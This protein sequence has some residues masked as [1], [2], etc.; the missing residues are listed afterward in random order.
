MRAPLRVVAVDLGAESGRCAVGEFDG[1]TIRLAEVHRFANIPVQLPD[2]LHWDVLRLFEEVK[3]G[4]RRAH[5]EGALASLGLDTWGVDFALLDRDGA[6]IHNPYHY[7]DRR[8]EGIL[9]IAFRRVPREEIFA[10]TGIQ[11]MPINTLYQLLAMA[12]SAALEHAH[13]LVMMPDLFNYWLTGQVGCE[14][15][16]ATTSQCYDPLAGGWALDL[17]EHLGLPTNLFPGIVACG[18]LLGPVHPSLAEEV[19]E[20]DLRVIATASHDTAAAV[21][22]VPAAGPNF[23]FVSAG[24]WLL[25]GTEVSSPQITP[26]TFKDNFTNEGGVGGRFLLMRNVTGLWLLQE[27]LRH[28]SARDEGLTY[29]LLTR[30]AEEAAPFG[31]V[32]DPDDESFLRP[33]DMPLRIREYCRSSGQRVPE[34]RGEVT[35]CILESLALKCR[36][37]V[38]RL[39]R[40]LGRGIEVI[41]MVGG[42][43]RNA[44][45]C[46]LTAGATG[47]PVE[48]GPLEATAMGNA[49]TQL[50][51]LGQIHTLEEMRQVVRQS[52]TVTPYA[53]ADRD[54]WAE[55]YDRFLRLPAVRAV[56]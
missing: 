28:W 46:R 26:Q 33:T 42:G 15:T 12:R 24:T 45:L 14:F 44:L 30:E 9:D 13:R 49:L 25:I 43:S 6:L 52:V 36:W 53:P 10:R 29:D 41:H 3:V 18:T 48:A 27:S 31:P 22:A 20:P 50:Q 8:T 55:A 21:A 2:G 17:L 39:E 5:L 56:P 32:V 51:T 4:V 11:I 19:G 1:S 16:E 23:A 34:N 7:R 54:R 38:D 35:R 37:V 47:R 40:L